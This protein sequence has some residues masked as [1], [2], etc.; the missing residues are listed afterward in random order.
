[1]EENQASDETHRFDKVSRNF[2]KHHPPLTTQKHSISQLQLPPVALRFAR[3]RLGALVAAQHHAPQEV[4]TSAAQVEGRDAAEK[5]CT[6]SDEEV[7][8]K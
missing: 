3:W 2:L 1:M 8:A 5:A 4:E 7:A 6:A